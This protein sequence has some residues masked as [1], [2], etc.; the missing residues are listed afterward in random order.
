MLF[1]KLKKTIALKM[2]NSLKKNMGEEKK[3]V[4]LVVISLVLFSFAFMIQGNLTGK[5]TYESGVID[6]EIPETVSNDSNSIEYEIPEEELGDDIPEVIE[7]S[8][9]EISEE[10][11]D[12]DEA[13]TEQDK[14]EAEKQSEITYQTGE[15]KDYSA[16]AT[17]IS[18][19]GYTISSSGV[20]ELNQSLNWDGTGS[21]NCITINVSDVILDCKEYSFLNSNYTSGGGILIDDG[22]Y[23]NIIRN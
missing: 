15:I 12:E 17:N 20:Y 2:A 7:E 10:E 11:S 18:S 22:S 16:M 3:V 21:N 13:E 9:E 23:F 19:C 5:L 4:L 6:Y 1:L 14:P 8:D